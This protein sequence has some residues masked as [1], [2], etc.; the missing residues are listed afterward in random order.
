MHA[1]RPGTLRAVCTSALQWLGL[2]LAVAVLAG[3][4]SALFLFS[5][6]WATRYSNLAWLQPF[7]PV[8]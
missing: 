6:D 2:C 8:K 4:A 3:S 5:L 1:S 7:L